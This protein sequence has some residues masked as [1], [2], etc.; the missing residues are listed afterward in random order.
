ME[1]FEL[2]SPVLELRE[3]QRSGEAD[4]FWGADLV[5]GFTLTFEK[6]TGVFVAGEGKEEVECSHGF[7]QEVPGK[8]AIT[9]S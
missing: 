2:V 4:A 1:V 6:E 3:I 9:E 8:G 7:F 5:E